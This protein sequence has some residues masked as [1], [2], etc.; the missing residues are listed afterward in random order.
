MHSAVPHLYADATRILATMKAAASLINEGVS[1]E[2]EA[3]RTADHA[4]LTEATPAAARG[5]V[6]R[7]S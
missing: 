1:H 3:S 2:R 6:P 4:C 7:A 5:K